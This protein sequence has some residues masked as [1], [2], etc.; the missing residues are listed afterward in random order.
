MFAL[1]DN[2]LKSL[3]S[4]C[5]IYNVAELYLFGSVLTSGLEKANDIDLLV[6]FRAD[7]SVEG[8]AENYFHLLSGLEKIFDKRID[9]ISL[10]SIKNP[11]FKSA[12]DETKQLL[13]A[14]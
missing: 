9:L 1:T 14:A 3:H 12:V 4:L 8:Y 11:I 5:E 2:Q 10:R 6:T 13:Y 7:M